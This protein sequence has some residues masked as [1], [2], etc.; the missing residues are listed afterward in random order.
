MLSRMA[1]AALALVPVQLAQAQ[2]QFTVHI[3]A[4]E[5]GKGTFMNSNGLNQSLSSSMA[6]DPGPGGLSSALTF[7]LLNPPGLTAGDV[8]LLELD[9]ADVVGDVIRFNAPANA[10]GTLVFY[11]ALGGGN[12]ADVGF[13]TAFYENAIRLPEVLLAD[14]NFGIVYTPTQGQ[15]GFVSGAA[16]PVTYTLESDIVTTPEPASLML[17]GTGLVGIAGFVKRKSRA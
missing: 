2:A 3:F 12:L 11:S 9:E 14:G 16:G 1:V 17:V 6:A 8:F 13:P 7:D 10:A 15:P 4:D 5:T